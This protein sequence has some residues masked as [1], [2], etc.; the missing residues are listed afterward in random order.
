MV[1]VT[2]GQEYK[3]V[4][5]QQTVTVVVSVFMFFLLLKY[6]NQYIL[7]VKYLFLCQFKCAALFLC[8]DW[9]ENHI[10]HICFCCFECIFFIYLDAK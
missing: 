10:I 8:C 5:H 3:V 1:Q 6:L 2:N 7:I 4:C 9:S